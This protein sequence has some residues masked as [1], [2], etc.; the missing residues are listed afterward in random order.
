MVDV[1]QWNVFLLLTSSTFVLKYKNVPLIQNGDVNLIGK[2][3]V[4]Q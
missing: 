1:Q 2:K 4:F 3:V